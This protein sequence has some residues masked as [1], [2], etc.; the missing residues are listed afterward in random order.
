MHIC[1]LVY[2]LDKV[3]AHLVNKKRWVIAITQRPSSIHHSVN[4]LAHLVHK[5]RY[6]DRVHCQTSSV[7]HSIN[8]CVLCATPLK[9][10]SSNETLHMRSSWFLVGPKLNSYIDWKNKMASRQ[11]FHLKLVLKKRKYLEK[12]SKLRSWSLE[13]GEILHCSTLTL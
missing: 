8:F 9:L 3:L 2:W 4:F 1:S 10:L 5:V 6:C 12:L 13:S 11:P 7:R